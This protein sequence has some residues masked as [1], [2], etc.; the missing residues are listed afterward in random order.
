MPTVTAINRQKRG[1]RANIYLDGEYALSLGLELIAERGV[2][3]G[4]FLDEERR[5]GLLIEDQRRTAIEAALHLLARRPCSE[6]ELRD[7]LRRRGWERLAIAQAV[8]RMKALGYLDD[9]AFARFWIETRQAA[10]PRS[11]RFLA[12]ELARK[13]VDREK[14]Q[15][16]TADLS[17][18]DAAYEAARRRLRA[19]RGLDY[20]TFQRRLGAFL[21]GRGFGYGVARSVIERCWQEITESP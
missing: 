3:V 9:E 2:S 15:T 10:T 19:L 18:L 7:A 13:G 14:T 5:D 16:L 6:R 1:R 20:P 11:R 21:A 4:S 8:E 12:Y 17:D